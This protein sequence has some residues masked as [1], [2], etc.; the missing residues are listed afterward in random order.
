MQDAFLG[1]DITNDRLTL[2][3]RGG[4]RRGKVVALGD[5]GP[6]TTS[7]S[8]QT[9]ILPWTVLSGEM[10]EELLAKLSA[11]NMRPSAEEFDTEAG[12]R[13]TDCS[14]LVAPLCSLSR[15]CSIL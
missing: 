8:Q 2:Y 6:D 13:E 9:A 15:A 7:L 14:S 1:R 3:G 10:D 12:G 4:V 11:L 5:K